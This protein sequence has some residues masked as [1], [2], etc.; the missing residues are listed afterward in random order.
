ML[1]CLAA[2]GPGLGG[3]RGLA[4]G[5]NRTRDIRKQVREFSG[6]AMKTCVPLFMLQNEG[7]VTL[8]FAREDV[9]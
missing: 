3:A 7:H 8:K 1:E 6:W 2:A 9:K 5:S 4:M